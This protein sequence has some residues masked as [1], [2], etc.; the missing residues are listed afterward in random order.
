MKSPTQLNKLIRRLK[1]EDF[2]YPTEYSY[3]SDAFARIIVPTGRK[4]SGT[5]RTMKQANDYLIK[6]YG[7]SAILFTEQ[8]YNEELSALRERLGDN[9]TY[10][11]FKARIRSDM[12]E[13][14][15]D[16]MDMTGAYIDYR[17][18]STEQ[19][20]WAIER[21]SYDSKRDSRGSPT[22]YE[23]LMSYLS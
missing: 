8:T 21:A 5:I 9:I 7:S 2:T 3:I 17:N 18:I 22:F 13:I 23:Y 11:G 12:I 1:S 10:L 19:M 14:I 16:A 20:K 4:D 15:E 6:K